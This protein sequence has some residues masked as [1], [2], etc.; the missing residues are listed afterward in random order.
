M[1]F[2]TLGLAQLGVALAV[3]APRRRG[4]PGNPALWVAVALSGVLQVGGVLFGPLRTLLG[5]EPLSLAQLGCCLAGSVLP[6]LTV[7]LRQWSVGRW[8]PRGPS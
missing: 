5:T 7:A 2:V 6:G 3:R 8:A 4:H 1:A